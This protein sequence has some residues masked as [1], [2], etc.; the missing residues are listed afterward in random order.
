MVGKGD[1]IFTAKETNNMFKWSQFDPSKFISS[2]HNSKSGND[3]SV[4]NVTNSKP[5]FEFN[6]TM[7]HIDKVDSTNIKQ[8]EG[9][10]NNAVNKLVDKMFKGIK[11]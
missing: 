2:I 11:Y 1:Q 10:A 4:S 7:M 3:I 5:T 9:I 8:M 6:G